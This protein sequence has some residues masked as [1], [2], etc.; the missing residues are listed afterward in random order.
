[1]TRDIDESKLEEIVKKF[2]HISENSIT[3]KI[4]KLVIFFTLL[5]LEALS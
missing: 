4:K 5:I 2:N 3:G 1:M